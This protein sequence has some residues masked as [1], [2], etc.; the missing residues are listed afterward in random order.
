I[1]NN[2]IYVTTE[3]TYDS[4]VIELNDVTKYILKEYK[5]TPFKGGKV[6]PIISNQ[7]T[8]DY[9]KEL[10]DLVGLNEPITETYFIGN[11]RYN[12]LKPK[13]EYMTSHIGRRNFICLCIAKGIPI[14]VIMKWTGHTDYKSMVPYIEVSEKT[15]EIEMEKLN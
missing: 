3:K 10:G 7:K 5:D 14:Q 6:L 12:D 11:R 13:F 2:K 8:N 4:L 9:V 1:V 15:K